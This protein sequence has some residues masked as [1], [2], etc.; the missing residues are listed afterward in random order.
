MNM[1]SRHA[2]REL[3]LLGLFTPNEDGINI[4]EAV[5]ELVEVLE[6]QQHTN[7]SAYFTVNAFAELAA[8]RTLSPLTNNPDEWEEYARGK[9]QNKRNLGAFSID[10][11]RTYTLNDDFTFDD[12]TGLA[13][14]GPTYTSEEYTS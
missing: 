4:G 9:W 1:T 14:P 6:N 8:L 2:K 11:G 12:V 3:E 13:V 7:H 10:G 5:M